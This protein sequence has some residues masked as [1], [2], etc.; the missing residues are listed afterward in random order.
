L[1]AQSILVKIGLGQAFEG[2]FTTVPNRG[3]QEGMSSKSTALIG[4]RSSVG[5]WV[6]RQDLTDLVD[7]SVTSGTEGPD[8]LKLDGGGIEIVVAVVM[9]GGNGEKS[10]PFT[11]EIKTLTDNITWEENVLHWRRMSGSGSR[12]LEETLTLG[13]REKKER[14]SVEWD[15]RVRYERSMA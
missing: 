5:W 8:D 3:E 9:A 4:E 2:V 12:V 14:E 13:C 6:A 7:D 1:R 10:N 11:L 15:W